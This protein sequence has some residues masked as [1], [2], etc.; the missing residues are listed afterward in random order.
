MPNANNQLH[1]KGRVMCEASTTN[2]LLIQIVNKN[3]GTVTN[4]NIPA[5]A[6]SDISFETAYYFDFY[7]GQLNPNHSYYIK[8]N[9]VVWNNGHQASFDV[10]FS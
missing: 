6:I 5:T 3:D 4:C 1:F 7:I 9:T 8:F 2:Q 10:L